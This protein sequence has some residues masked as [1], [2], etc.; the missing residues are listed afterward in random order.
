MERIK[1]DNFGPIKSVDVTLGDLNIIIGP[2]ASGKSLFL[3]LFKLIADQNSIIDTLR[4]Y[5]YILSKNDTEAIV[6]YYF[7]EGL[8]TLFT[9]NTK[10]EFS[11]KNFSFGDMLKNAKN[12]LNTKETVFY[13]PAQRILSLS[14][15]RPKNF[16]EFDGSAPFVLKKFSE[17]LRVFIQGG[18]G[19]PDIIFP[20]GSRLKGAVKNSINESI[21]HGAKVLIDKSSGQ[22][23][24][25]LSIGD[26]KLPFMTWSA[27][28]KEF[29]PLLL[30]MYCLSGPPTSVIDK[31]DFKWVII[32]EPEMGLHPRAIQTVI[33]ELIELLKSDYKVIVSTHSPT[34]LEFA[35]VFE[36]LKDLPEDKFKDALCDLFDVKRNCTVAN[37]FDNLQK[38]ELKTYFFSSDKNKGGVV[39]TD[40]S[41]LDV[42]DENSI[43]AEWGGL[44]S[45]SGK[46][47]EVVGRYYQGSDEED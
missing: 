37:L 45:F 16:M 13:I 3:E 41:S 35:W 18:L 36:S 22:R 25:K 46:A 6:D 21:F 47:S 32:E 38:K 15:G 19:N 40:I 30:A 17:T 33:L 4:K 28:Q 31:R 27:G 24:M 8:H 26:A 10:V 29:M 39:S 34:L 20:M 14:D 44:S 11:G 5:N 7:G 1:V 2:Q 43:I 12:K 9:E 23:K 42:E